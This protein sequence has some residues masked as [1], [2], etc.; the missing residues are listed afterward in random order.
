MSSRK[1]ENSK[2]IGNL[3]DAG[4]DANAKAAPE[5]GSTALQL[6]AIKGFLGTAKLLSHRSV[7][8]NVRRSR[9]Y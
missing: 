6:A 3:L 8:T 2:L 9:E 1:K 4:T 5:S 7:D